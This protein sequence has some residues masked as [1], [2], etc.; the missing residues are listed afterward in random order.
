[1]AQP[2]RRPILVP[3]D[4]SDNCK[5]ALLH[6]SKAADRLELPLLVLHVAHETGDH[7][8]FYRS[9]DTTGRMEP[10]PDI[11][12]RMLDE[13]LTEVREMDEVGQSLVDAETVV[14]S[15]LP[16][17]RILEVA[18][19]HDASM[20]VMG[21]LGKHGLARLWSGSVAA[22]V[23][24]HSKVPVTTLRENDEPY[25]PS[26]TSWWNKAAAS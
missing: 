24:H 1:M 25:E 10:L 20:I 17:N 23:A 21:T 16:A 6:A 14:V 18:D 13:L 7:A 19:R 15:G 22:H 4:F 5:E 8:G 11:A 3:V 2:T 26:T 12:E 9:H